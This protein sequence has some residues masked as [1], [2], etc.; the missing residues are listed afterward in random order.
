MSH[1]ARLLRS[2]EGLKNRK[3]AMPV[4]ARW[5]FVIAASG[6]ACG[7]ASRPETHSFSESPLSTLSSN[8]GKLV[9]EVRTAPD[10]PPQ[11][12]V[13]S[14]QF[15]IKNANGVLQDGLDIATTPW[16]PA[17]GHGTSVQPTPSARGNGTYVLDN[18][19]LFMPGVW[20][21]RTGFSGSVTDSA[22]PS[23]DV[24]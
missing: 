12:G 13:A 21:L 14:V 10:Q 8:D 16:M 15:V 22:T 11:R 7:A 18:V 5:I 17:M 2:N 20:E 1:A 6:T 4:D 9:I 3:S 24:P 19:Y 23:F